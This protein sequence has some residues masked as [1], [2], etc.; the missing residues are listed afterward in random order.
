MTRRRLPPRLLP[1]CLRVA[2]TGCGGSHHTDARSSGCDTSSARRARARR[3][4]GRSSLFAAAYVRFLD[5][6]GTAAALPDA[7]GS[8]RALAA[9]AGRGRR[10]L[11]G[12]G[13]SFSASSGQSWTSAQLPAGSARRAHTFYARSRAA[14]ASGAGSSCELTPPDFVQTFAPAGPRPPPPPAGSTAPSDA[15]RGSSTGYLPW[16]YGQGA[17]ARDPRTPP[18][19]L[20]GEPEGPSAA[21]PAERCARCTP[22]LRRTRRAAPRRRLAGA[23]EHHRRPRDLRARPHHHAGARPVARQQRRQPR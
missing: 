10:P 11:A 19:A 7:T 20:L 17:A 18:A 16:L 14:N 13:R 6:I 8:V 21:S 1:A 15:A 12:A 5:G 22:R 4:V 3:T 2:I 23:S 9:Q